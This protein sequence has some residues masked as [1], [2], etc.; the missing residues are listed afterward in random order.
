LVKNMPDSTVEIWLLNLA[1]GP[2]VPFTHNAGISVYPVWSPQGTEILSSVFRD[3]RYQMYRK[4]ASGG[5]SEDL[6]QSSDISQLA[7]DWIPNPPRIVY[8]ERATGP[9]QHSIVMLPLAQG[10]KPVLIDGSNSTKYGPRASPSG[11]WV[12]YASDES[13]G[14]EIYVRSMPD[15]EREAGPRIR[16]STGGGANAAWS[17]DGN[18]L[19]Y[20]S[21]DDRLFSVKL[22]VAG[23][24]LEPGEPK[25]MFPLGGTSAFNGAI[26]W[27]PIG[28]GERFVV[29]RSAPVTG[30]DNRINVLTN[31]QVA[32]N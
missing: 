15:G 21:P 32:L 5:G 10:G 4:A 22:K 25:A 28:N 11:R 9:V 8:S 6:V 27:E 14:F 13:G 30:H 24:R 18:T 31:W 23:D 1:H 19:F 29:L 3:G 17:A 26:Y 7:G 2:P 16:I 12:A 20:N